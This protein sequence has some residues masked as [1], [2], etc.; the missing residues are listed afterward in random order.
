[1]AMTKEQAL[2]EA[3]I[4]ADNIG[5]PMIVAQKA[6]GSGW[7]IGRARWMTEDQGFFLLKAHSVGCITVFPIKMQKKMQE[8]KMKAVKVH[9]AWR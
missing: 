3:G 1:M 4:Q 7:V 2:K 6:D 9:P 5:E 8:E